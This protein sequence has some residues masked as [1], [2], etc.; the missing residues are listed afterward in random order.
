MLP[1]E[2]AARFSLG[3]CLHWR[4]FKIASMPVHFICRLY[5]E[6]RLSRQSVPKYWGHHCH[7]DRE[8]GADEDANER[9]SGL[10]RL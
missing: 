2:R 1:F 6:R 4:A 10:Q 3:D 8:M 5:A 7:E 9:K